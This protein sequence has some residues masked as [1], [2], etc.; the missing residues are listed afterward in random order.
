MTAC[1][2]GSLAFALLALGLVLP[3]TAGAGTERVSVT[4]A[5]GQADG[6]SLD[7]SISASGRFVAFTSLAANLVAGDTNGYS[8]VFVHDR[9]TGRTTRVS[10]SSRG[11]QGDRGSYAAA[12]S[13]SGRHVAFCSYASN[14]A[15][16]DRLP[17]GLEDY[18][19]E[20][21]RDVFVHDRATGRTRMVSGGSRRT[22][23]D[24]MR[25]PRAGSCAPSISDDGRSVA[26]LLERTRIPVSDID[27]PRHVMLWSAAGGRRRQLDRD[28]RGGSANGD[29][30]APAISGNGRLVAFNSGATN[31]VRGDT[32]G[33]WDTFVAAR[34]G[35]RVRRVSVTPAG[36]QVVGESIGAVDTSRTGRLVAFRSYARALH[37]KAQD[38]FADGYVKDRRTG[39]VDLVSLGS[40]GTEANGSLLDLSLSRDGRFAAFSTDAANLVPGETDASSDVFLRDRSLGR[41]AQVTLEAPSAVL[42]SSEADV[43]P[44]GVVAY[45]SYSSTVVPGD[46]NDAADVFVRTP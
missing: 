35:R 45:S 46:T 1:R 22:L 11:R 44:G 36:G 24:P 41:I 14:L 27:R 42:G 32:N 19:L 3:A 28:A 25:T 34:S 5:G 40:A 4:G 21:Y 7:P 13:A 17:R 16:R 20:P 6:M 38:S 9:R 23:R 8:D 2:S 10:V 43:A 18:E 31:L 15:G 30:A 12:I 26:Y 29:A 33:T 39:A 37:P